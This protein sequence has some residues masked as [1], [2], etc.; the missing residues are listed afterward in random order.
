MRFLLACATVMAVAACYEQA[1]AQQQLPLVTVTPPPPPKRPPKATAR[2]KRASAS[3]AAANAGALTLP[4]SGLVVPGAPNIGSGPT[5]APNLASQLT[6]PGEELNARPTTRPGEILEAAPGLIVTQHSGEGKANQYLLRGYNLDHGTDMAIF[7]DGMPVNMPTHAHG[8]GYAD[9]NWLMPETVNSVAVRKGPYFADVGDFGS[10]GNLSIDLLDASKSIAQVT[11]GSFGYER[12]FA[13]SSAKLGTGNFLA[14]AEVATYNGP[15]INPD[16]MRKLNGFL[17]Y[18]QGT[19]LDGFSITGMA[20]SNRWNS[21]DQVPERAI[22]SGQLPRFGAEDP[23]D[24]GNTSRF[25]LSGRL[26][27]SDDAGSWRANAYVIQSSLDLF[28]DFTYFLNNPTLGDQ[29]HQHDDRV[30]AG[31]NVARTLKGSLGA[32]PAEVTVGVQS[33]YDAIN[34]GLTDTYQRTFLSNIRSDQ[35]SEG[36]VGIYAE[37][38]LRWSPWFRTTLGWRGDVYSATVDSIYDVNN[39]GHVQASI[40]SP[41]FSLVLGPFNNTEFFLGAGMGMHSNDARGATITEAPTDPSTKLTASP[42]LVRT[43]GAEVGVRSKAIAGLDTSVSLFILNQA[44]EIVFQG[45]SGDTSA[46]RPSQRYGIEWTN[47]YRPYSWIMIDGD[48][49]ISHARFVGFDTARAI[50]FASLAGYPEAQIGNAPGS[51]IPNAPAIVASAGLTLGEKTGWF[52]SLRWRY[53]GATPLTEDNAFRSP[54]V[55]IV[56]GRAGYRF[57]NGWAARLDALN[58]LNAKTNQITY[59]YGSLLRTDSLFNLCFPVQV[60]PAAVCQNGVMDHILHPIE[61]LALRLTLTATF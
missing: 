5:I 40:G 29:F 21:T 18:T 22:G 16:E 9:L 43:E 49:A 45:D 4:V 13:M 61:P 3:T 50:S 12:L 20:Y 32:V 7:I 17:R 60:A 58:L 41:K 27:K 15:W 1:R 38:T 19:V 26:A 56:N 28:N 37:N 36:S 8:Q 2:A 59:A 30:V 31:A 14:A 55:S 51:Y 52:G 57:D 23:S 11:L 53:L 46:S 47:E 54:A 25:S 34:L 6:V 35:V 44:S 42:L 48:L 33:R 24:G 39:S 10:A